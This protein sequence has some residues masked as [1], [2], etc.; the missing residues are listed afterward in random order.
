MKEAK[1]QYL[2]EQTLYLLVMEPTKVSLENG[3][4]IN[5]ISMKCLRERSEPV[6]FYNML[7]LLGFIL[8]FLRT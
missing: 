4:S 8:M 2:N 6:V 7:L 3:I 1:F 5:F